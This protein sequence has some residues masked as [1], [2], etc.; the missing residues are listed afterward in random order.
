MR[1][2]THFT[3]EEL[4][5]SEAAVRL[6]LDNEPSEEALENMKWLCIDLLEPV[7][8][9]FAAPLIIS[10]CY[11]APLVNAAIGGSKTSEHVEGR[12]ADFRVK[13]FTP[14][15]VCERIQQNLV[16]LDLPVNQLILEFGRWTHISIAKEGSIPKRQLL[17]AKRVDGKTIYVSG[18][19]P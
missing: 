9:L 13:A 3:K 19:V 14:F 7:R 5:F 17:T 4:T 1:L 12:A 18:I 15:E 16:T 6:G 11:R 2:S 8:Q 10:S